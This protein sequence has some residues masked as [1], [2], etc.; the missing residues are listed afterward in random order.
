MARL[1]YSSVSFCIC[2]LSAAS[3][4]MP[5]NRWNTPSRARNLV[6][7]HPSMH[8]PMPISPRMIHDDCPPS[9]K[10]ANMMS[11][12]T[13]LLHC[14]RTDRPS[15]LLFFFQKPMS[16]LNAR[17]ANH[18]CRMLTPKVSASILVL[19]PVN[20]SFSS[21]RSDSVMPKLFCIISMECFICDIMRNRPMF[22]GRTFTT[23]V[24]SA[25]SGFGSITAYSRRVTVNSSTATNG[26]YATRY[27]RAASSLGACTGCRLMS[28]G[29]C[30]RGN[31]G[32]DPTTNT[33]SLGRM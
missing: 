14:V 15:R 23:I 1:S 30:E 31:V 16:F 32:G 20:I 33:P 22:S 2:D 27:P 3:V 17:N 26:R 24:G 21:S 10:L 7:F 6:T 28:G 11:W 8:T 29:G 5:R 12:H 13:K 19:V 4:P 25:R 9:T 18:E